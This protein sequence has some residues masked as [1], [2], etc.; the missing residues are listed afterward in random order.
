MQLVESVGRVF[1]SIGQMARISLSQY[2]TSCLVF[3]DVAQ[4]S[5]NT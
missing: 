5:L 1:V 3:L 4:L 2:S